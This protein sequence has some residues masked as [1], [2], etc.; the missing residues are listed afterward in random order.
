MQ[1][2]NTNSAD[3]SRKTSVLFDLH[4]EGAFPMSLVRANMSSSHSQFRHLPC[5]SEA[6]VGGRA[7]GKPD[8]GGK[9]G[10]E[11]PQ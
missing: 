10:E 2:K 6:G 11:V 3:Q 7:N 4:T 1:K 9:N 5:L 8:E